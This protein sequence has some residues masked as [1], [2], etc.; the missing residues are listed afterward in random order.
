[1][2]R[3][4]CVAPFRPGRFV[5]PDLRIAGRF[6]RA[7][8]TR[9]YAA[10]IAVALALYAPPSFG[11]APTTG[12]V[13]IVHTSYTSDRAHAMF[14]RE[15][16]K[17]LREAQALEK[18]GHVQEAIDKYQD[19]YDLQPLSDTETEL[20]FAQARAGLWLP[21]ARHLQEV[22]RNRSVRQN[23]VHTTEEVRAVFLAAK[24]HVGTILLHVNVPDVRITVDG[25]EVKEWPYH[26]EFY[27]EPGKHFIKGIKT[28]YW[29][30]QTEVALAAGEQKQ[31]SIAMQA[32]VHSQHIG[33][34][35]PISVNMNMQMGAPPEVP[36]WPTK[37]MIVSGLGVGLG[38]GALATGLVL[39]DRDDGTTSPT[40]T[41][42]AVAGGMLGGLSLAGL[43]I[44]A[45]AIAGRPSP[46]PIILQPVISRD[47]KSSDV[48]GGG[49]A[50]NGKW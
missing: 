46:P 34:W 26:E 10:S 35:M 17:L 32:R 36:T 28:G 30:N 44:G 13:A 49:V 1:M 6:V 40:W 31:L 9:T 48:E 2:E 22:L 23:T 41:G 47:S 21:A 27:V 5:L 29:L 39:R 14:S 37:L 19:A 33:Y 20:A 42:V 16:L 7:M 4:A 43:L 8:Q 18:G 11:D 12:E 38:A 24:A 25:E 50:V 45:A 15:T 3:S